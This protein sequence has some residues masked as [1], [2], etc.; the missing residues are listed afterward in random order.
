[1][2]HRATRRLPWPRSLDFSFNLG[3]VRPGPRSLLTL[4][5]RLKLNNH[6]KLTL[7]KLPPRRFT[8]CAW[9]AP[10]RPS[11]QSG[12]G[13]PPCS[14]T[15]ADSPQGEAPRVLCA[16]PSPSR[17]PSRTAATPSNRGSLAAAARGSPRA[18]ICGA[19]RVWTSVK[20]TPRSPSPSSSPMPPISGPRSTSA[21]ACRRRRGSTASWPRPP[22][23]CCSRPR[24]SSPRDPGSTGRRP[25]SCPYCAAS[26]SPPAPR[27]R[28][29]RPG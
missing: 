11:H 3:A 5:R 6:F 26:L 4:T 28:A 14:F 21:T 16:R 13:A 7:F 27:P 2:G 15:A 9:R 29:T 12:P 19:R 10:R 23:F 1:M 24:S 8:R 18:G 17:R 22:S 25:R 20:W